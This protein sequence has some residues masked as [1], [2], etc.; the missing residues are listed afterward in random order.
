VTGTSGLV[1]GV[2]FSAAADAGRRTWVCAASVGERGRCVV[3][4]CARVEDLPPAPARERGAALARLVEH[5]LASGARAVGMDFPF[6]L[7]RELAGA[8]TW[9][10][11]IAA[12]PARWPDAGAF[13]EACAARTGG[14]EPKRRTDLDAR[15][16]FSPVNLR[17]HRQ[18]FHG[19]RDVLAPLV[20]SG[21]VACAPMQAR[22]RE[23]LA[24][25]TA[26]LEICP[27]STLKRL[28]LYAPYKGAG[29]GLR[30]SRRA[31]LRDLQRRDV[32][33]PLGR[34]LA[35]VIA[36]DAGGDALDSVL[37]ACA[38]A[39]AWSAFDE[40]CAQCPPESALEAW[41]FV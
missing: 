35:G 32:L 28:A 7:P 29:D 27:A 30:A 9:D 4:S 6:G 21:R 5:V 13:R 17:L 34:R 11:F 19:L 36:D 24:G 41:V 12:L 15:T 33:A 16:P 26:L 10:A 22:T 40:R 2:D 23:S 3:E 31:I 39:R 25:R 37:A 38:T 18:T 14:R 8:S 1:L 20:A